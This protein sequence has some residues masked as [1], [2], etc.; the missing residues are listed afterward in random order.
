MKEAEF[1]DD[2]LER[3]IEVDKYQVVNTLPE[4]SYDSIT[5]LMAHICDVP[6]SLVS[7]LDKDRNFL[8]SHHG[9]PFNEDTR[10]RSFCGHAILED[11][12]VMIVPDASKDERFHDNPLVTEMGV[13][14]YAGAR[15][16]NP[17]GFSLGT[18]CV[19]DTVPKELNDFQVQSLVNMSKQVM[20]ILEERFKNISLLKAQQLLIQRNEEMKKFVF[21]VSHDLKAPLS[22]IT[23]LSELLSESLKGKI[24]EQSNVYLNLIITS[25]ISLSNYVDR[26]L[27]FYK[28]DEL[29][30][31]EKERVSAK[32]MIE[33][34][35][36]VYSTE[37]NLNF[38]IVCKVDQI[39]VNSRII[40]QILLN[41][42]GNGIKYNNKKN[43]ELKIKVFEVDNAYKFEVKDNGNGMDLNHE[44]DIFKM[45]ETNNKKDRM[46]ERG[47]G[48]GLATVKKLIDKLDGEIWVESEPE[49]GSTFH[50]S[51]PGN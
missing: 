49:T 5:A 22:G 6:I 2:E 46:G 7:I 19:F 37:Q 11:T 31:T 34:A 41:L 16:I 14:F 43:R 15:L 4:E 20:L 42:I 24:D 33:E 36:S 32:D 17:E 30:K 40:H 47:T 10:D 25:G 51:I 12:Q 23:G 21:T 1:P 44:I 26:M 48:I 38:E 27:D 45:F 50:F 3:Q 28:S 18:L 29:V 9:V 13:R 39:E 35:I 8:K